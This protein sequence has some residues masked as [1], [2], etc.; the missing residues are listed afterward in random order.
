MCLHS[1]FLHKNVQSSVVITR[2]NSSHLGQNDR[3]FAAD[4]FIFMNETFCIAIQISLK[5]VPKG[6]LDN[7]CA[8]VQVMAWR[9]TGDKPLPEP[10]LTH[11]TDACKYAALG[12][13]GF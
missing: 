13:D 9:G 8:R 3:H 1:L 12:G 7:K 5:F 11:F 2:V 6:P 10:I 4:I